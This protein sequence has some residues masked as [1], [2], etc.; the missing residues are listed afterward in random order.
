MSYYSPDCAN[1]SSGWYRV[2]N[3]DNYALDRNAIDKYWNNKCDEIL[4][5]FV[6]RYGTF[7]G[8]YSDQIMEEIDNI[9]ET[10]F[11]TDTCNYEYYL[12]NRAFELE[13]TREI[14]NQSHADARKMTYKCTYCAEE[15]KLL[16]TYPDLLRELGIPPTRCRRCNYVVSRYYDFWDSEIDEKV[17][18]LMK[19]LNSPR[20]CEVCQKSF[21]LK[22]ALFNYES[23]GTKPVDCFYPNLFIKICPSC[24]SSVFKD[25]K[26]GTIKTRL[27]RLKNLFVFT[28][29]I[30]TQDF[31]KFIYLY[32]NHDDLLE[33]LNILKLMR[34]PQGYSEDCGNFFSALVQSGILPEGSRRMTIGTMVLAED[35]HLCLSMAE[36]EIDDFLYENGI[37]HNKEVNYPGT[38]FRTDWEL[39]DND[40]RVFVEYFGLMSN[41][42]Y[43][44]KA[45][46]KCLLAKKHNINLIEIYPGDDWEKIL[47][48]YANN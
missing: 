16:D 43:A 42:D 18:I 9:L 39:L 10:S 23:F 21:T 4:T 35:G 19:D 47:L 38:K 24:F 27:H 6:E 30:P 11:E 3:A 34:T 2:T 5:Q 17:Q 15:H 14:W 8:V 36:K 31:D 40:N 33:L 25:Y 12:L 44:K 13:K 45:K 22:N 28:G 32:R 41:P 20:Q 46:L 29:K 7:F 37:K 48:K 26:K 1:I